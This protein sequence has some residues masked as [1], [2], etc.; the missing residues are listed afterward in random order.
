MSNI[1]IQLLLTGLAAGVA[2]GMFGIGG[3]AMMTKS[4]L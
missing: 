4:T 2:G 1:R 3:G